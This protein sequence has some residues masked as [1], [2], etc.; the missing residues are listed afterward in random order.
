MKKHTLRL[1]YILIIIVGI[2]LQFLRLFIDEISWV[3]Y[4]GIPIM[5]LGIILFVNSFEF[6]KKCKDDN[7]Y[8]KFITEQRKLEILIDEFKYCDLQCFTNCIKLYY[9]TDL[10]K[11]LI[12]FTENEKSVLVRLQELEIYDSDITNTP[13]YCG[14]WKTID[15]KGSFY[16]DLQCAL[17]E[18]K[19]ELDKG[20]IEVDIEKIKETI[21]NGYP[22]Y[23]AE[24]EWIKETNG[25]RKS[26]PYGNRYWPQIIIEGNKRP[27]HSIILRNIDGIGKYK[28]IA[29]VKYAFP[30]APNDLHEN[31]KF[32]V[33]EGNRKVATGVITTK[34]ENI[35]I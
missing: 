10:K 3:S 30:G 1:F 16:V 4:I 19:N 33:C 25:G 2:I 31:L 13:I 6:N 8:N 20:Y 18:Y 27:Q 7:I 28:T 34:R 5:C 26:I 22:E 9:S 15:G 14:I 12:I 32:Y 23:Y 17:E 21:W 29:F 35:N 24:I 11:R